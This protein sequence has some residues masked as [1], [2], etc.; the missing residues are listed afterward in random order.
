MRR[1]RLGKNRCPS[2]EP[3][4]DL[5]GVLREL[6]DRAVYE[7]DYREVTVD[8]LYDDMPYEEAAK[9]LIETSNFV[10]GIDWGA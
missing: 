7:R 3:D 2:A 10:A 5:A 9:A 6:F 1:Q 8:L 4:I